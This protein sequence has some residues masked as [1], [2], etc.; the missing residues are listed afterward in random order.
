MQKIGT[1]MKERSLVLP[2]TVDDETEV[3]RGLLKAAINDG[4][5]TGIWTGQLM[6]FCHIQLRTSTDP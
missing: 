3:I 4:N 6:S 1:I 5:N 2:Y